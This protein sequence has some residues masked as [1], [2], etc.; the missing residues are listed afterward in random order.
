MTD[1]VLAPAYTGIQYWNSDKSDLVEVRRAPGQ[2]AEVP[3]DIPEDE[4]KRL[5]KLG[6]IVEASGA[7]AES[8]P[9]VSSPEE[10]KG[11]ASRAEWAAYADSLGL[12]VEPSASREDIKQA[13]SDSRS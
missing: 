1:Y 13:I 2:E 8:A 6:A 5:L 10:P 4:A 11:N 9:E 12:T 7:E 3:S